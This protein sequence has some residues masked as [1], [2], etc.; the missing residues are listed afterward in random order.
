[1]YLSSPCNIPHEI[2]GSLLRAPPKAPRYKNSH[3]GGFQNYGRLSPK[4]EVL[5][6][7]KDPK[8]DANFDNHLIWRVTDIISEGPDT[9]FSRSQAPTA[10]VIIVLKP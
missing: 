6:H 3:M 1:M 7:I 5:Y 10:I 2:Q 4:Y 8:R 9:K